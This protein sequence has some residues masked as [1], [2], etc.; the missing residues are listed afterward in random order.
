MNQQDINNWASGIEPKELDLTLITSALDKGAE[1]EYSDNPHDLPE[2]LHPSAITYTCPRLVVKEH[3]GEYR[4]IIEPKIKRIFQNGH[5]THD[6]IKVYFAN[7]GLLYGN[8]FDKKQG[9][10][11]DH[12]DVYA[13][14]T[15]RRKYEGIH[16]ALENKK[17]LSLP[18]NPFKYIEYE[19]P[20]VQDEFLNLT[21]HID[22]ILQIEGSF[23]LL[24][25][26]SVNEFYFKKAMKSGKPTEHHIEQMTYYMHCMQLSKDPLLIRAGCRGVIVYENKNTQDIAVFRVNFDDDLWKLLEKRARL[27]NKAIEEKNVSIAEMKCKDIRDA[28]KFKCPFMKECFKVV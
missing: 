22:G 23:F 14:S 11:I 6:R 17:F 21:G 3:L 19:E 27:I 13:N 28:T 20:K 26:K 8:W 12:C 18:Y 9:E 10:F 1:K 16:P 24:E 15:K 25:I 7:Q 5:Y 4:K 2:K